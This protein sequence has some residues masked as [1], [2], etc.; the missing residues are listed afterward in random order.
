MWEDEKFKWHGFREINIILTE[1][2]SFNQSREVKGASCGVL[3]CGGI[4]M[5]SGW[6]RGLEAL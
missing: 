6:D 4:Y 3:D 2:L 5:D 1:N